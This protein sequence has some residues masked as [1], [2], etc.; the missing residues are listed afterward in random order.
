MSKR[1]ILYGRVS[2]DDQADKGYSLPSQI[3]ACRRYAEQLGYT[4]VEELREDYS[5]ATPMAERPE[6]KRLMELLK[7]RK[8]DAIIGHQVDRLSRDTVDLLVSVRQWLRAGVEV[9]SCDIGKIEDENN[10]LLVIKGWQGSDERKKIIE[11]TTRGRNGKVQAGKVVG[12]N[13]PPY[14]Y[15]FIHDH[16][17]KVAGLEI[18]E[19]EAGI[20]RLVFRW[21]VHEHLTMLAIAR[22]LEEMHIPT[23][24]KEKYA[25]RGARGIWGHV[26]VANILQNET[27][28][29]VWHFGNRKGPSRKRTPVSEQFAVQVPAII[30]R[31]TWE[32]AQKLRTYN[33]KMAKRNAKHDYLLRGRIRC[34]CGSMMTGKASG[35]RDSRRYICNA[36]CYL[37][38]DC[39]EPSVS[40]NVMEAQVWEELKNL[41]QDL[42][43]LKRELAIAQQN[44][45]DAQEPK[46]DELEAVE[47]NL[48]HTEKQAAELARA[49]R[50]TDPD[51]IVGKN[52]QQDVH[53]TNALHKEQLQRRDELTAELSARTLTDDAI[54]D[55]LQYARDVREGIES[56]DFGDM[57]INL[58]RLRVE[59][60][61]KNGHYTA[62]CVLGKW[63]GEV[64]RRSEIIANRNRRRVTDVGMYQRTIRRR[65]R[66]SIVRG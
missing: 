34:G 16:N 23:P 46:R 38:A 37:K 58:E 22:R 17:N 11:R 66:R 33:K 49:L 44:E 40:A 12:S 65:C 1:A 24:G 20:V 27:Y 47:A 35:H 32:A 56:A 62:R 8:A 48:A 7:A 2:T 54:G 57:R 59:V 39:H 29:G 15:R 36:R 42:K 9:H 51:E 64:M 3:E 53:R 18:Y 4:V 28:A 45:I 41:F 19:V 13:R 31:A 26:T 63:E 60:E 50:K 30:D 6:G 5:G 55:I 10:I 14:G 21:Y 61:V 25:S 43:R 52:L